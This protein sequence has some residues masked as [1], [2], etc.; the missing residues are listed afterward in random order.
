[1][2]RKNYSK[3]FKEDAL[4]IAEREGVSGA[5]EKLGLRANQIYDWRRNQATSQNNMPKGMKGAET[6]EEYTRRLERENADLTEANTILK[7]A[8]GFLVGR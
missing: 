4:R 6:L 8:M 7:K 1:M 5:C 3:E 2:T